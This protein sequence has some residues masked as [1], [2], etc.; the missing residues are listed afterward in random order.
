M[1]LVRLRDRLPPVS[2]D[3]SEQLEALY[4]N[5]GFGAGAS[6]CMP[7]ARSTSEG[8]QVSK[9]NAFGFTPASGDD[10]LSLHP[11]CLGCPKSAPTQ[12]W[13]HLR[14]PRH[15]HQDA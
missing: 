7:A 4:H 10:E 8:L 6:I 3:A 13:P 2:R 14:Y 5:L 11:L 12:P 9:E 1:R 15:R